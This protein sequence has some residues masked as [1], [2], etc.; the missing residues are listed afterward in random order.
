MSA[1]KRRAFYESQL[2]ATVDVLFENENKKGFITG[3][4]ENYVKVR[5]P[6]NPMLANT[7]QRVVLQSIDDEGVV[8]CEKKVKAESPPVK[9]I[10]M[11]Y[12][13]SQIQQF[14]VKWEPLL[15]FFQK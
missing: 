12:Y 2:G 10:C 3:F 4:S 13:V 5:S 14:S 11:T 9:E 1:K 8:R 7:I 15:S 6:W